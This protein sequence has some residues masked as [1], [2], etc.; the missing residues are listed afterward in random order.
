MDFGILND[1]FSI[2]VT[3][4]VILNDLFGIWD[5]AYLRSLNTLRLDWVDAAETSIS[6]DQQQQQDKT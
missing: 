6:T 1:L 3:D 4:F 2:S 5:R